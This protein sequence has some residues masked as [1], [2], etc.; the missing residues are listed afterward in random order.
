[1]SMTN[2][3]ELA[4]SAPRIEVGDFAPED[5]LAIDHLHQQ[6]GNRLWPGFTTRTGRAFYYVMVC[7]GLRLVEQLLREHGIPANNDNRRAWFERWERLWALAICDSYKGNIPTS[8]SIRGKNGVVRAWSVGRHRLDYSLLSRQLELGALGAYRSSLVDHG[9]L[10]RDTLRPTPIGAEL[11]ELMWSNDPGKQELEAYARACLKPGQD[12]VPEHHGRISLR[13]FGARCRLSVIR[14]RP[15]V[16]EKL[17]AVLLDSHPPPMDLRVLPEMSRLMVRACKDGAPQSRAFLQSV[18]TSGEASADVA[19][20]ARVALVFGDLASALR[21]C[22]DRTYQAVLD[23]GYRA[24]VGEA[25]RAALPDAESTEYVQTCLAAW[26]NTA[27]AA[28][29]VRLEAHGAAFANTAATLDAGRPVEFLANLLALHRRV[30]ATRGKSGAWL[31]LEGGQV[32][33]E[34]GGYRSWSLDGRN[35]VVSFKHATM[36]QLLRDLG[37]VA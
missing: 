22:F 35:W 10:T 31:T 9:L 20:N 4:W 19:V 25:A 5:P 36:I 30:Q 27:I 29:R 24:S 11:A 12:D 2:L 21:A 18:A 3:S 37:R 32:L 8:D 16:R 28:Q 7:Y 1:M 23:G 6:I 33:M 15:E 26:R 17:A 34:A 13:S 14:E